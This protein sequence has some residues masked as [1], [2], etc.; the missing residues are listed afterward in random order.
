LDKDS[1][2]CFSSTTGGTPASP[3]ALLLAGL[4]FFRRREA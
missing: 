4:L 3:W 1:G 2:G